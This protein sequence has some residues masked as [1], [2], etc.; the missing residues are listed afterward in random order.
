M[1]LAVLLLSVFR[2]CDTLFLQ[3]S[4]PNATRT[5][6]TPTIAQCYVVVLPDF[7][8]FHFHPCRLWLCFRL[9]FTLLTDFMKKIRHTKSSEKNDREWLKRSTSI[10]YNGKHCASDDE[11]PSIVQNKNR[12]KRWR[13]LHE[14]HYSTNDKHFKCYLRIPTRKCKTKRQ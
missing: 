3:P 10:C 14:Q 2:H 8:H 9:C 4:A 6:A 1:V 11:V 7:T 12:I 13:E 5:W